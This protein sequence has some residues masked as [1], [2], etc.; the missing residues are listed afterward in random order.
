MNDSPKDVFLPDSHFKKSDT[1]PPNFQLLT[2][3]ASDR[4]NESIKSKLSSDDQ[5]SY[6][7]DVCEGP[8]SVMLT[9]N[10]TPTFPCPSSPQS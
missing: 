3:E 7:I 1:G 5:R 9:V 8:S 4:I 2:V 10:Y 6:V